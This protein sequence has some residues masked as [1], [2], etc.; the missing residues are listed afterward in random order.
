MSNI[1]KPLGKNIVVRVTPRQRKAGKILLPD[2]GNDA[3]QEG[4]GFDCEALAVGPD[5]KSI[6]VGDFVIAQGQ[7]A[8]H[9]SASGEVFGIISEGQVLAI[10]TERRK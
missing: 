8:K 3:E 7:G 1:P 6:A 2:R 5:V 4:G 10:D 9:R